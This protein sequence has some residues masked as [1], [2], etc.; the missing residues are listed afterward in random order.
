MVRGPDR[1]L[2]RK[3]VLPLFEP[4]APETA[5]TLA[6]R[7]GISVHQ[8]TVYNRLKELYEIDKIDSKKVGGRARVWWIPDPERSVDPTLIDE[9]NYQS[10]KDP[11]ILRALARASAE[12]SQTPMTSMEISEEV[13]ETKDSC[14]NR[15]R[16]MDERGLIESLKAGATS[17]VWWIKAQPNLEAEPA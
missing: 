16:V 15:L 1:T 13:D 14:Y 3:D 5:S 17:K 2:K 10:A 11:K 6:D 7:D 4:G 12:D 8:D 9:D